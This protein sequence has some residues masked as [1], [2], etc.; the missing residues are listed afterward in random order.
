MNNM[1]DLLAL[2]ADEFGA[3]ADAWL[4]VVLK[5]VG[6]VGTVAIG[7]IGVMAL[8]KSKL[9]ESK[10]L[11]IMARQDRQS[12]KLA[13][14]Q[15]DMTTVA[16]SMPPPATESAEPTEVKVV[17]TPAQPVPTKEGKKKP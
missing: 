5:L 4:N 7:V 15:Q 14:V 6:T 12:D 11:D 10:L 17:N 8:V 9:T 3:N 13:A 1:I 16:M 2:T